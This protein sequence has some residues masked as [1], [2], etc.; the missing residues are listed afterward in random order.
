MDTN[1]ATQPQT[2]PLADAARVATAANLAGHSDGWKNGLLLAGAVGLVVVLLVV[3]VAET[4][5]VS[6]IQTATT[7]ATEQTTEAIKTELS[8][9]ARTL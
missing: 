9:R 2:V 5:K 4:T 7:R 6:A 3:I 1:T 8:T